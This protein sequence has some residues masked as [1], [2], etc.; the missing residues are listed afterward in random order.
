MFDRIHKAVCSGCKKVH[1]TRES[2]AF[3]SDFFLPG[4]CSGCGEYMSSSRYS[5]STHWRHVIEKREFIPAV[6]TKN[7]LTWLRTGTW[8]VVDTVDMRA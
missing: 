6:R 8:K 3:I 7:P 2:G 1:T 4:I 5:E